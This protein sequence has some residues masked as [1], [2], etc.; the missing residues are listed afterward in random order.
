MKLGNIMLAGGAVIAC[1]GAAVIGYP[2]LNNVVKIY[3]DTPANVTTAAPIPDDSWKLVESDDAM[4]DQHNVTASKLFLGDRV[5]IDA[6]VKCLGGKHLTYEFGTFDAARKG[7]EM[8]SRPDAFSMQMMAKGLLPAGPFIRYEARVDDYPAKRGF[9]VNPAYS[10]MLAIGPKAGGINSED[11]A[12]A[13]RLLI[14][15]TTRI[16]EETIE[17]SQTDAAVNKVLQAC[18]FQQDPA[19]WMNR[20]DAALYEEVPTT[21]AAVP[22]ELLGM[23][24][25]PE[26]D[27]LKP[28]NVVLETQEFSTAGSSATTEWLGKVL[29]RS[30]QGISV[31]LQLVQPQMWY[32]ALVHH[33]CRNPTDLRWEKFWAV[34]ADRSEGE[35]AVGD[36]AAKRARQESIEKLGPQIFKKLCTS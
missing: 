20:E 29:S 21:H 10:N 2:Y 30:D 23:G 13:S 6:A 28:G 5:L 35:M 33:G 32:Y 36:A 25:G 15:L 22:A 19:T 1:L 4:T 16:G 12:P 11:M 27:V 14:R 24:Y 3:E 26:A 17:I 34:D 8:T 18:G 9:V 31:G 7:V